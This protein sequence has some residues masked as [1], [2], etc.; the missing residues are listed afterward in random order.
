MDYQRDIQPS[1]NE[2]EQ[3]HSEIL[4]KLAYQEKGWF[5]SFLYTYFGLPWKIIETFE[6][7]SYAAVAVTIGILFGSAQ[8]DQIVKNDS[9]RSPF[10][11]ALVY[12]SGP[13]GIYC[14]LLFKLKTNL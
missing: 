1:S 7:F 2:N 12:L 8:T 4:E 14:M 13:A 3:N 5:M 10:L 9:V 6:F 11:S